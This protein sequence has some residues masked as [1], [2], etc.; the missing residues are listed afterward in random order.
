MPLVQCAVLF[1]EGGQYRMGQKVTYL[2]RTRVTYREM[3]TK[4][5]G[6]VDVFMSIAFYNVLVLV[7]F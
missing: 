7:K 4:F 2:E 6:T 3:G 1:G 5:N